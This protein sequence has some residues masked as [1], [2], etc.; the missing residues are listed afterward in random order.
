MSVRFLSLL[1]RPQQR[2]ST[3][4]DSFIGEMGFGV[5]DHEVS[6]SV[7]VLNSL[8]LFRSATRAIKP[9][10]AETYVKPLLPC[11]GTE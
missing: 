4:R 10:R 2:S 9:S 3:Q 11:A 5:I 6:T 7:V 1:I 8:R